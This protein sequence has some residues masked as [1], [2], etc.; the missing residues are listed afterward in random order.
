[1]QQQYEDGYKAYR[2]VV[3]SSEDEEFRREALFQMAWGAYM[4]KQYA[5][6]MELYQKIVDTY[7]NTPEAE[8][9]RYWK[10]M[11]Y[12]MQ[13]DFL[14]AAKEFQGYVD[15]YPKD[16]SL[17]EEA[18]WRYGEALYAANDFSNARQVYD[19][20]LEQFPEN[21]HASAIK[22]RLRDAYY[23]D[24]DYLAVLKTYDELAQYDPGSYSQEKSQ[25]L[26]AKSLLLEDKKQDAQNALKKFISQYP[27]SDY[28][29]EAYLLLGDS[30]YDANRMND[31]LQTYQAMLGRFPESAS[32]PRAQYKIGDALFRLKKYD[33]ALAAF[34]QVIDGYNDRE[35]AAQAQYSIGSCYKEKQALDLAVSS[36]LSVINDYT[37]VSS[38]DVQKL[39]IGIFFQDVKMYDLAMKSF[40][41]VLKF[42]KDPE[43][44]LEAQYYIGETL[45]DSGDFQQ[46]ILEFFKVTY[47]GFSPKN[48]WVSTSKFRIA[49]IYEAQ[50]DWN[51]ALKIYNELYNLFGGGDRRGQTASDRM[52]KI[53]SSQEQK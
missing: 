14:L 30:F 36:Y 38:V 27:T 2:R 41:Q 18:L 50:G 10:G 22:K 37:D 13:G 16:A 49:E 28:V 48:I 7:P 3:E 29:E 47:M 35:F 5:T 43:I 53:Q 19:R 39:S 12:N 45:Y 24:G 26:K 32:A 33:E 40:T 11:V 51:K 42:T 52:K 34:Q 8:Q 31:A 21:P 44:K 4:V 46:A 17:Y 23:Q 15:E 25:L 6:A 1:M 9:A 20:L